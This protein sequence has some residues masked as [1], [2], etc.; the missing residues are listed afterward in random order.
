MV[1][2]FQSKFR[3]RDLFI[4]ELVLKNL[5]KCWI[6]ASLFTN[7]GRTSKPFM[8]AE[9]PMRLM[10]TAFFLRAEGKTFWSVNLSNHVI[11]LNHH[12]IIIKSPWNLIKNL[13]VTIKSPWN[14]NKS[15]SNH[16]HFEPSLSA[17]APVRS[18]PP[19]AQCP[20][21][22]TSS[23]RRA[24]RGPRPSRPNLGSQGWRWWEHLRKKWENT[25]KI[26]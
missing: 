24:R 13:I 14:P 9:E 20:R 19:A 15:P 7:L 17:L 25:E 18:A 11:P 22:S 4:P 1:P 3:S 8:V 26:S 10:E 5:C 2:A 6:T 21:S 23:P 12:Q 16:H